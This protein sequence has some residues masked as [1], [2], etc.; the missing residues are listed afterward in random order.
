MQLISSMKD[1]GAQQIVVEMFTHSS[2][3]PQKD[4]ILVVLG[5]RTGSKFEKLLDS[6]GCHV[7]YLSRDRKKGKRSFFTKISEAF[8]EQ[9]NL[10]RV[11]KKEKPDIVHTHVTQVIR[12]CLLPIMASHVPLRFHTLHSDPRTYT[13]LDKRIARFAFHTGKVIPLCLNEE[14]AVKAVKQYRLKR[15]EIVK[16]GIDLK[17]IQSLLLPQGEAREQLGMEK[18]DFIIGTLGRLNKVK[19]I[20]FLIDVFSELHGMKPD[21]KLW[22]VGNG[23]DKNKIAQLVE[24]KKLSSFINLY[25]YMNN[26]VQ[27]YCA[28][29]VFV[30]TTLHESCSLVT[31]EAQACG[32][33]CLVSTGVPRDTVALSSTLRLGLDESPK[34]W[35]ETIC[36][37]YKSKKTASGSVKQFDIPYQLS[38]LNAIYNEAI[39]DNQLRT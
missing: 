31:L 3:F 10:Y 34:K 25:G 7:I 17:K 30:L 9:R 22:I 19:N 13:G 35:A 15:Y 29:D 1:G 4:F 38:H 18:D 32:I 39:K 26:P 23:P 20:P 12:H 36:R 6:N 28:L 24:E 2:C 21:A 14:Q 5:K 27:L 16:N 33:P 8:R 11:L 37:L